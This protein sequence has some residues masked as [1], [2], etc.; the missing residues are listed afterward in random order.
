VFERYLAV[1]PWDVD[2]LVE[3][4]FI[5]GVLAPFKIIDVGY[6]TMPYTDDPDR[7]YTQPGQTER[8]WRMIE[9]CRAMLPAPA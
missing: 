3:A 7:L 6:D 5:F 9:R 4:D 1:H 2:A 8:K